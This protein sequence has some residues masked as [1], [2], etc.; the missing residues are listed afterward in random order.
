MRK[1]EYI[2]IWKSNFLK[3]PSHVYNRYIYPDEAVILKYS[4]NTNEMGLEPT[5][6]NQD[7]SFSIQ[8]S[9]DFRIKC[10]TF[11]NAYNLTVEERTHHPITENGDTI[12]ID[13]S[14]S[15][16]L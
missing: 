5:T 2:T 1:Q 14:S 4:S 15:I 13:M 12:W 10:R 3:I 8:V 6:T 16:N 11:L 7:N 9:N